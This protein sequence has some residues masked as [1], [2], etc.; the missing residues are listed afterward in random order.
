[1]VAAAGG[2]HKLGVARDLGA[3]FAFGPPEE[4]IRRTTEALALAASGRL[5]PVIG[6]RPPLARAADA[7]AAMEDRSVVGKTMLTV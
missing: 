4:Q 7:H 3:D 6:Q 2:P 5:R 1:M